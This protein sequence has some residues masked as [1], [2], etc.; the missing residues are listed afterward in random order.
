MSQIISVLW[1]IYIYIYMHLNIYIFIH[2]CVSELDL[3]QKLD[4]KIIS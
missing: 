2:I 1:P 4:E 3:V